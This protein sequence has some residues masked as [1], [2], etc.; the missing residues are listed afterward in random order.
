MRYRKAALET[1]SIFLS[2]K[3]WKVAKMKGKRRYRLFLKASRIAFVCAVGVFLSLLSSMGRA[4]SAWKR[5]F[6][7]KDSTVSI[8]RDADGGYHFQS[9]GRLVVDRLAGGSMTLT[10]GVPV[11]KFKDGNKQYWLWDGSENNPPY[12]S[13]EVY[14]KDA[15][16][17]QLECARQPPQ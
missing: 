15:L 7:C 3:C 8:G 4:E 14:E 10:K 16:V 9:H 17:L 13:L 6:L 11:Y 12:G 1:R 2:V 5:S